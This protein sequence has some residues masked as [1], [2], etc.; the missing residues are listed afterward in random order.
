M[1]NVSF[2][3][4]LAKFLVADMAAE[5]PQ[6]EAGPSGSNTV[7]R[8]RKPLSVECVICRDTFE[9]MAC[10]EGLCGHFICRQCTITMAEVANQSEE[11]FPLRCC[12]EQLPVDTFLSFLHGPLLTAFSSKCAEAATPLNF[13][14][15]C[16][17]ETCSHFIG[18]SPASTPSVM[19]CPEC[20]TEAC[21]R[22]KSRAHPRE[23]CD[24]I[25][26]REVRSLATKKGWKTCPSCEMIVE[27]TYG[28]DYMFCRCRQVF[29]YKC[30]GKWGHC[31]CR[32]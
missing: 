11:L 13:R 5:R 9:S 28:C 27:R 2:A 3:E 10:L 23:H 14:V 25:L 1:A 31:A 19:L 16:P 4:L 7:P 29:C 20:S 30:G 24:D 18:R 12:Q 22:C 15:Y 26:S 21:S 8:K 6:S 17:N 32:R